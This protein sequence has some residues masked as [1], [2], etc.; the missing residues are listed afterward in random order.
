MLKERYTP[1][2]ERFKISKD[3]HSRER[4]YLLQ[5]LQDR[6]KTEVPGVRF[7]FS[8][9][10]SL[11][12]GKVLRPRNL[13]KLDPGNLKSDVDMVC[14]FDRD[15][16]AAQIKTL[17]E[18][19]VAYKKFFHEQT[20]DVRSMDP[21]GLYPLSRYVEHF[22]K[23]QIE[24]ATGIRHLRDISVERISM[25]G[26]DSILGKLQTAQQLLE[27]KDE[28]SEEGSVASL[29][30]V[31]KC[32]NLDV[33]GGLKPYRQDFLLKL[34]QMEPVLA[35]SLWQKV[36]ENVR[37]LERTIRHRSV[38]AKAEKQFPDTLAKAIK[39]YGLPKSATV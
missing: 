20:K 34:S 21:E 18:H 27:T 5:G 6:L 33:G 37:R 3:P 17:L 35:E 4:M 23:E 7:A 38:P 15:D 19:N 12:K 29:K 36:D 24:A 25:D 30:E 16:A 22:L 32:F 11:T 13:W 26:E 10:G 9:F 31:A 2:A 8:V 1:S 39:Y 28:D 14:F